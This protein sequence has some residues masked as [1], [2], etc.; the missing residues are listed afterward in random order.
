[1][2]PFLEQRPLQD[3]M[4]VY[5]SELANLVD[6][7]HGEYNPRLLKTPLEMFICSSSKSEPLNPYREIEGVVVSTSN[8]IGCAGFSRLG[9]AYVDANEK[10]YTNSGVLFGQTEKSLRFRDVTDGTSNVFA[11]GERTRDCHAGLWCG[12]EAAQLDGDAVVAFVSYKMNVP[13][14]YIDSDGDQM[15]RC[16]RAFASHHPDGANFLLCDGSSRFVREH[17][18]FRI[19]PAIDD[20]WDIN[21]PT[22]YQTYCREMGIYQYLGMREDG[23]PISEDF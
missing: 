15:P 2:L 10:P 12:L 18:E 14:N 4:N 16:H 3:H 17:I 22:E 23:F 19:P 6:D 20:T 8:Y 11:V 1:L 7:S 5:G 9:P 21:D 13:G